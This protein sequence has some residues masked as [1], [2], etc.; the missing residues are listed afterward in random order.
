MGLR[1]VTQGTWQG[2]KSSHGK[3]HSG[4][5]LCHHPRLMLEITE[6]RKKGTCKAIKNQITCTAAYDYSNCLVTEHECPLQISQPSDNPKKIIWMDCGIHAREWIAPAFCQ[7]FVKEVSVFSF[8][9][10]VNRLTKCLSHLNY[11]ESTLRSQVGNAAL[12]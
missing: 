2:S 4:G 3:G 8:L 1:I 9:V 5:C 11:V 7:W 10:M 6:W 12:Y